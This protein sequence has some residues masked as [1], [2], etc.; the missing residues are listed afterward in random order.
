VD[1]KNNNYLSKIIAHR[2]EDGNYIGTLMEIKK[3]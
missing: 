1:A 2:Q 3:A